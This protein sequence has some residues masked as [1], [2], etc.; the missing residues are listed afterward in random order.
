MAEIEV[1]VHHRSRKAKITTVD[2]TLHV[3]VTAPPIEGAANAAVIALLAEM[4]GLPRRQV[5][6]V[7]GATARHKR[8]AVM[9][10]RDE[11]IRAR[12]GDELP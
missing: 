2:G 5:T 4:L 12:I 3:W 11:E 9:G 8:V 1:V 10:M 6:I 7:R